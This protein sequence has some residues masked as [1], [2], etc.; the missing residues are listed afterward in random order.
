M[1][2]LALL[3]ALFQPPPQIA[4]L[5]AD[6]N[7]ARDEERVDDALR[8]YRQALTLA[9]A[10]AE[11]WW[12]TG[13]LE[14][15]RDRFPACR[16]AFRRFT[17]LQTQVSAGFAFLGLCEFQTREFQPAALHLE[18][19]VALGLPPA[20]QLADV[21]LFHLAMLQARL[22]NP[23]RA[24]QFCTMLV[25]RS[26]PLDKLIPVAGTA[27]LRRP[28]FPHEL[29]EADRD[30]ALRLGTALMNLG[31]KPA[32]E[33][34]AQFEETARLYPG[35][36]NVHYTFATFLL[37]N[38]P[39]RGV[40]ELKKELDLNPAHVPALVSLAFEYQR[41]GKPA[42]AL[43]FAERAAKAAPSS[44]AA[45]ACLGR[46]LLELDDAQLPAA[47][48][49]LEAAARLAPDSPQVHF[50]LATAYAKAGRKPDAA[51]ERAEFTRLKNLQSA[52]P[53]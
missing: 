12:Q 45:R 13:T 51:R 8:L 53:N 50:S 6:A 43:P 21:A 5:A 44:F 29:P 49:E 28:V 10:W 32:E 30:V 37:V 3:L 24:L 33:V 42:D 20:E 17:A 19:A 46:V 26:V 52:Q 23:E 7:K 4:K 25:K 40:E 27:A 35:V 9:P 34:L 14:Y 18:K 41:R 47:I 39:D 1:I 2:T 11:G 16:D 22:G 31:T 36:P 38:L 48:R 15:A